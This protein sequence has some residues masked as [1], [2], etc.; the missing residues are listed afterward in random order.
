MKKTYFKFLNALVILCVS[1]SFV[2]CSSDDDEKG[3][4]GSPEKLVIGKWQPTKVDGESVA[5]DYLFSAMKDDIMEIKTDKTVTYD[6]N[7]TYYGI[8]QTTSLYPSKSTWSI[9]YE[10]TIWKNWVINFKGDGVF[11]F[12][13]NFEI[14]KVDENTLILNNGLEYEFKRIK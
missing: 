14:V 7:G 4:G 8:D 6:E 11:F 3:D 12:A 9:S 1:L 13:D 2:S 10:P 5:N